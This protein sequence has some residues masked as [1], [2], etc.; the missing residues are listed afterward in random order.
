MTVSYTHL[1]S[2]GGLA[3]AIS[4]GNGLEGTIEFFPE[5]GKYHFD[6]HRK[7]SLCISPSEAAAYGNICPVCGKKLTIGVLHRVEQL[8]DRK[9]D[10][11]LSGAKP[12]ES[13]VPL[14]EVIGAC[15]GKSAASKKVLEQYESM[16]VKLGSEFEILRNIPVEDL[17]LIH[18][19]RQQP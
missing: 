1:L 14:P 11:V 8:A 10:F 18:I 2:Y 19:L 16:L 4:T 7:C 12:F 5:E 6:G 9:E 13:L 15:T 3:E 17:S